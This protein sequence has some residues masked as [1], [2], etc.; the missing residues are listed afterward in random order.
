MMSRM[1]LVRWSTGW[2]PGIVSVDGADTQEIESGGTRP[3]EGQSWV[4]GQE[5][6]GSSVGACGGVCAGCVMTRNDGA[7]KW[8]VIL[9][10]V[11]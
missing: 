6:I 4:V 5:E 7:R 1:D 3:Q 9:A 8:S 11:R 10:Y 2:A